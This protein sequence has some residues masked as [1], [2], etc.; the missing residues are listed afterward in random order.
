MP[1]IH[2]LKIYKE[3]RKELR[4]SATPQEIILWSRLNNSQLGFKFRRQQSIGNFIVDFY[5]P[6]S[7][8]VI[9]IDGGGHLEQKDYDNE[10]TE[11]FLNMG[12]KVLRFWNSEIDKN[13]EGV[14]MKIK[15]EL[16]KTT[17]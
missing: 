16:E 17:P 14:M 12:C 9:E 13:L 3:R 15:K 5:C 4:N 1:R 6:E 11:Y 10:R 2:N 7:K 8:L